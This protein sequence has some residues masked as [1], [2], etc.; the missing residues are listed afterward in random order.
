MQYL[1]WLGLA[2][3]ALTC[4]RHFSWSYASSLLKPYCSRSFFLDSSQTLLP[5][6][7]YFK[8]HNLTYLGVDISKDGMIIQLQIALHY[9]IFDIHNNTHPIS[10]NISQHP[11]DQSH[12]TYHHDHTMLYLMQP[13]LICNNKFPGFTTVQQNWPNTTLI[14]FPP[15][16]QR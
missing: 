14:N 16:L 9:H 11:I 10:K 8:L 4:S 5:F 15:F 3:F 1:G 6:H 7:S 13:H 2:I 12:P